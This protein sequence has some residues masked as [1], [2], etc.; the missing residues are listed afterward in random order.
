MHNYA[1][2]IFLTFFLLLLPVS[3]TAEETTVLKNIVVMEENNG[4]L[5]C[6]H[7]SKTYKDCGLSTFSAIYK[8]NGSEIILFVHDTVSFSSLFQVESVFGKARIIAKRIF[9][10]GNDNLVVELNYGETYSY[11]WDSGE[12]KIL[13]NL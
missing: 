12:L 1:K 3:A 9:I 10:F 8:E 4:K 7:A 11:S 2:K 6:K 13:H 5:T